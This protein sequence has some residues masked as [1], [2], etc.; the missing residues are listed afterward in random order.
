MRAYLASYVLRNGQRGELTLIAASSCAA[1]V[2]AIDHFG[3]LLRTC[4]ARP[5]AR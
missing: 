2:Q 5:L 1:I 4:S 3:E